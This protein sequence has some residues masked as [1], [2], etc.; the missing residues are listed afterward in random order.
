MRRD[1]H[2]INDMQHGGDNSQDQRACEENDANSSF[3]SA[4]YGE[5]SELNPDPTINEI[6]KLLSN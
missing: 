1:P 6:N 2:H 3:Y 4:L 5:N